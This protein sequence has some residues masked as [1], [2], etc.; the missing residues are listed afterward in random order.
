M[1][2]REVDASDQLTHVVRLDRDERRHPQQGCAELAVG[3]RVDDAVRAQG[4]RDLGRVDRVVEVD[5]DDDGYTTH[6]INIINV[7]HILIPLL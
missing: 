7:C 2:E 3:L 6:C 1:R 4:P 5:R